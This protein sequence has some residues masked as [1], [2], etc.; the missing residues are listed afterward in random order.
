MHSS[1]VRLLCG[2]APLKD[3]SS[4]YQLCLFQ[5]LVSQ[6][7]RKTI[8]SKHVDIQAE[9]L[10]QFGADRA[11]IEERCLRRWLDEQVEVAA[12]VVLAPKSG[13]KHTDIAGAGVEVPTTI[14][15]L[16]ELDRWVV[17]GQAPADALVQVRNAT[18]PPFTTLAS[19]PLCRYP[20]YPR[21]ISGDAL[22][23]ASYRC[24]P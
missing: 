1:C 21:Y 11:N 12:R 9:Q 15:M 23:A 7:I 4:S 22:Q 2:L 19:R 14:D 24:V 18:A 17:S 20:N 5:H 8:Q 6:V 3:W 16:S 10:L 13:T